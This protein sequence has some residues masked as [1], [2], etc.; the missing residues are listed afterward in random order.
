LVPHTPQWLGFSC[1]LTQAFFPVVESKQ[2]LIG[3][4]QPL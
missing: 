3:A 1:V 4:W 2:V